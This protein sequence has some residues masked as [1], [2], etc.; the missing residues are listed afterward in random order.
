MHNL[1][2]GCRAAR[3]RLKF[4]NCTIFTLNNISESRLEFVNFLAVARKLRIRCVCNLMKISLYMNK[5]PFRNEQ[6]LPIETVCVCKQENDEG[7]KTILNN[8]L[9]KASVQRMHITATM[10]KPSN[11]CI[12]LKCSLKSAPFTVISLIRCDTNRR[13]S[14]NIIRIV[15][16]TRMHA[17]SCA[18]DPLTFL[19]H[20]I[21]R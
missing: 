17:I 19:A 7:R 5:Q 13:E 2:C 11:E 1:E 18:L 15:D 10:T 14:E 4:A 12:R 8:F 16:N 21:L 6:T 3:L 20:F 9:I